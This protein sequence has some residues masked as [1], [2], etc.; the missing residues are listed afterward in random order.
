MS[1]QVLRLLGLFLVAIVVAAAAPSGSH[2]A[3]TSL[4]VALGALILSAW[5]LATIRRPR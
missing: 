5:T 2:L 4:G 1:A 3:N